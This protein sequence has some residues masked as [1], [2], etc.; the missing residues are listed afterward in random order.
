MFYTLGEC[1]DQRGEVTCPELQL[2][3]TAYDDILYSVCVCHRMEG[4]GELLSL[5]S[6]CVHGTMLLK[7]ATSLL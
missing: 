7:N 4:E 2:L 5:S 6:Y 3:L 1:E